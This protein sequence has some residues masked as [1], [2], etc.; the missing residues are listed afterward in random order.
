M[1]P[2]LWRTFPNSH[3]QWDSI[4]RWFYKP[5]TGDLQGTE[6][7]YIQDGRY[8]KLQMPSIR[9]AEHSEYSKCSIIFVNCWMLSDTI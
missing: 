4:T 6:Y 1:D 9:V 5:V 3:S 2:Q 7:Y 8:G